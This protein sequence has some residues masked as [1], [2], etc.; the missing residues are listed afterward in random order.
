MIGFM[1]Y[2]QIRMLFFCIFFLLELVPLNYKIPFLKRTL[3]ANRDNAKMEQRNVMT[4]CGWVGLYRGEF[5]RAA[6]DRA[7]L[8]LNFQLYP[9]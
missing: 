7:T 5:G 6:A 4:G 1:S 9:S 8:T 3:K 2:I